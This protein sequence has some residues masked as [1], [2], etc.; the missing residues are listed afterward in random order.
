[1]L[2]N[3]FCAFLC[4]FEGDQCGRVPFGGYFCSQVYNVH[5]IV[6]TAFIFVRYYAWKHQDIS[7]RAVLWIISLIKMLVKPR[8]FFKTMQE[9]AER[10]YIAVNTLSY[11]G[12]SGVFEQFQ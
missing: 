8:C 12:N 9:E 5:R 4:A 2:R 7:G 1:N 3:V 11:L 10:H 6:I